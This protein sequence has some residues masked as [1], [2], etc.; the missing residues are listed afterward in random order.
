[1]DIQ[2]YIAS[3]NLEL[4][5]SS[6]ADAVLRKEIEA[7][8][9][10]S[11]E[12]RNELIAVEITIEELF[13]R[14]AIQPRAGLKKNIMAAVDIAEINLDLNNLPPTSK[15]SSYKHWLKAVEHLIPAEPFED[16]FAHILQ[17]NEQLA[18]T[19]VITKM[20]VPE[21][22]HEVV[23]ESFF[24]LKVLCTCNVGKNTFTLNAG[25]HLD[26]PLHTNHDIRIDSPY[27]IAILQHQFA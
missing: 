2:A 5:C 18:Q 9:A 21:E 8:R 19:L 15:Y 12:I 27:V 7:L 20:N 22:I 23:S 4:Y 17:Q 24:I 26:I 11:P 6:L 10:N 16:F 13:Q 1:M 14:Q 25:D 3:G